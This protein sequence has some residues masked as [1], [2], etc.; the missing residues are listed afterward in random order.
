MKQRIIVSLLCLLAYCSTMFAQHKVAFEREND[1]QL[2]VLVTLY[3]KIN[4]KEVCAQAELQAVRELLFSGVGGS[5]VAEPLLGADEKQL[6]KTKGDELK[7]VLDEKYG[8]YHSYTTFSTLREKGKDD[9]LKLDYYTVE[10]G[11]N[12]LQMRND[13]EEMGLVAKV[14]ADVQQVKVKPSIMI[15]PY[16]PVGGDVLA[17]IET[18]RLMRSVLNNLREIF[19]RRGY[20]TVDYQALMRRL[21]TEGVLQADNQQDAKTQV[22]N[23]SGADICL[24]VELTTYPSSGRDNYMRLR[25]AA[26][27]RATAETWADDELYSAKNESN[28]FQAHARAV[29]EGAK[30][31]AI[32][33]MLQRKLSEVAAAGNSIRLVLGIDEGSKYTFSSEV[34]SDG[35]QL[36]DAIELWVSDNAYQGNYKLSSMTDKQ[37]SFEYIKIPQTTVNGQP[38]N[39]NKFSFELLKHLRKLGITIQRDVDGSSIHVHIK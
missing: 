37:M 20:T 27:H 23:H 31:Q 13:L 21:Q 14:V 6:N 30:A 10:V 12:I 5:S 36:S 7:R 26:R 33:D 38:M 22:L 11:I 1:N 28:D 4:K 39:A 19:D 15:I 2:T 32:F 9:V 8:R 18:N 29:L 25:L 24:E 17:A 3:G 16:V 35:M 34:G